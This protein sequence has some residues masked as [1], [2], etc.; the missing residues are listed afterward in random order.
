MMVI[1]YSIA[2]RRDQRMVTSSLRAETVWLGNEQKL[3]L[4]ER[5]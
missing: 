1:L 5:M 2:V 3:R 4:S